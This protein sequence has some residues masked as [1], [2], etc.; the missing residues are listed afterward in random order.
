[1]SKNKIRLLAIAGVAVLLIIIAIA[2]GDGTPSYATTAK[3]YVDQTV[4]GNYN[5]AYGLLCTSQK[6]AYK[7]A[8]D[9]KTAQEAAWKSFEKSR[10]EITDVQISGAQS[11]TKDTGEVNL[12]L[13]TKKGEYQIRIAMKKEDGDWHYCGG[14]IVA[15]TDKK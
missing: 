6:S 2:A 12:T 7:S 8:N 3:K 10:G 9:L 15:N 14:Q 11:K 1:M 4:N 13:K 5:D